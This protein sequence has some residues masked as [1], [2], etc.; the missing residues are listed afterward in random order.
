MKKKEKSRGNGGRHSTVWFGMRPSVAVEV[1]QI[2]DAA[3]QIDEQH[4]RQHDPPQRQ[5]AQVDL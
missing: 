5:A 2:G 1:A 3:Q 4:Q